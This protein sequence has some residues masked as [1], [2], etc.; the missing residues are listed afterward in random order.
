MDIKV[1]YM[2]IKLDKKE[3][4]ILEGASAIIAH[5]SDIAKLNNLINISEECKR[6]VTL[7]ETII[8]EKGLENIVR[9]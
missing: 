4:E 7:L 2:E 3:K 6:T 1:N 5:I 9:R 8:D